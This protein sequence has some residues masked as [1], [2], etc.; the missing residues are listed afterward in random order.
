VLFEQSIW[1]LAPVTCLLILTLVAFLLTLDFMPD[2][3]MARL[4]VNDQ[5]RFTL[6]Q[7]FGV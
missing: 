7:W 4:F 3:E 6:V 5:I 1:R 2:Y